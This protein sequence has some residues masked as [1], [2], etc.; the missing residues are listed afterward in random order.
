MEILPSIRKNGG[1]VGYLSTLFLCFSLTLIGPQRAA[2]QSPD[3]AVTLSETDSLV[4]ADLE[5]R[6]GD[7]VFDHSLQQALVF[8]LG[9]SP[10]LNILSDR[11]VGEALRAMGRPANERITMAVAG[12]TSR[13]PTD[14]CLRSSRGRMA[15][16]AER[17]HFGAASRD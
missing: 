17:T 8:E 10:Y 3:A 6:T 7:A 2:S 15:A 4:L 16:G 5:N 9:Q 1:A 11:K 14:I 12:F 13:T